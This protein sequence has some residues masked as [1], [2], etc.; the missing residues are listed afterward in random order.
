VTKN[1]GVAVFL[2]VQPNR[3]APAWT[4]LTSASLQ[5]SRTN[6][7]QLFRACQ[8]IKIDTLIARY[9]TQ[10]GRRRAQKR[11]RQQCSRPLAKA[12]AEVK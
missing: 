11:P 1:L 6:G 9:I 10:H 8:I 7:R 12:H 2:T 4:V 3:V 5:R